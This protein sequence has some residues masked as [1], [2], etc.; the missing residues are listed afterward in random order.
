[1]RQLTSILA[2][3]VGGWIIAAVSSVEIRAGQAE[4]RSASAAPQL[5][6][7]RPL[8]ARAGPASLGYRLQATAM[9]K[10]SGPREGGQE[11]SAAGS[12]QRIDL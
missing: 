9:E 7:G 4:R 10:E 3:L 5:R 1:M 6:R 8:S 2:L 11:G 12:H